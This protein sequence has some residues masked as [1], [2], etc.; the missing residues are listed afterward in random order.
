M[1]VSLPW[2]YRDIR[3]HKQENDGLDRV[4]HQFAAQF[5]EP[6]DYFRAAL[7]SRVPILTEPPAGSL[8]LDRCSFLS[9][10]HRL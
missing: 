6:A 8:H 1:N 9:M 4:N 5:R 10:A 7:C 3:V 2:R